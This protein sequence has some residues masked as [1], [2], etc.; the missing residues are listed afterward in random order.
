MIRIL[1]MLLKSSEEKYT[2]IVQDRVNVKMN[3]KQNTE[4]KMIGFD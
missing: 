1:L 2:T 4:Q 3:Y